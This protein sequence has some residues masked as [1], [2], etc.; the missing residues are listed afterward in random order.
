MLDQLYEWLQNI[1]FFLLAAGAVLDALPG[2][3]YRKYVRSFAGM[4]A[5]LL[6]ISPL[7]KL[8]GL[9]GLFAETYQKR[10]REW[11]ERES[12]Q[13]ESYFEQATSAEEI[14]QQYIEEAKQADEKETEGEETAEGETPEG[15]TVEENVDGEETAGR[16]KMIE[17]EE[18][19]IGE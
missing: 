13:L 5:V 18:I 17:V 7:L 1:V 14:L 6:L 10:E 2:E 15:E 19:R 16:E 11:M 3:H 8:G 4:A 12:S 9:A